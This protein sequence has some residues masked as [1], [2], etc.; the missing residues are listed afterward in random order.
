MFELRL[1]KQLSIQSWGWWFETPSRPLW[2]H[3]DV[4][5][6]SYLHIGPWEALPEMGNIMYINRLNPKQKG[7]H[8]SDD[9][10][11]FI[12]LYQICCT[13]ISNSL[14]CVSKGAI[15][16]IGVGDQIQGD[17]PVSFYL[18]LQC[19]YQ[20]LMINPENHEYLSITMRLAINDKFV[21]DT[22]VASVDQSHI[23]PFHCFD[24]NPIRRPIVNEMG[25]EK[26]HDDYFWFTS[27]IPI[28]LTWPNCSKP[29]IS[30]P[31]E[32]GT[33]LCNAIFCFHINN[34]KWMNLISFPTIVGLFGCWLN[35][36]T[37]AVPRTIRS[38]Q[39]A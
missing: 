24:D 2:R 14:T 38:N 12:F 17:L 1:N 25:P 6:Q 27:Q 9:N 5:K 13:L 39:G 7:S 15:G 4:F 32:L 36:I 8:F 3:C 21:C 29:E 33:F 18:Q 31:H 10:V 28:Q 19:Q 22:I 37:A 11:K 16:N 35:W 34:C 30:S 26:D 20:W 23:E